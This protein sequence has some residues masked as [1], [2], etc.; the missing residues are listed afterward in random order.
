MVTIIDKTY[1]YI[2]ASNCQNPER[3]LD[4]DWD[5]T[6][7][8]DKLRRIDILKIMKLPVNAYLFYDYILNFFQ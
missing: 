5:G 2:L 3:L 6:A 7:C 4:F 1:L 8:E